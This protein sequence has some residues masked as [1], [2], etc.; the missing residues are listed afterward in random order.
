MF[1]IVAALATGCT[2]SVQPPVVYVPPPEA[3]VTVGVPDSYA[4]E[5]LNL[6]GWSAADKCTSGL[7]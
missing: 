6:S 2:L 3:V 1:A 7:E 4:W 5:A